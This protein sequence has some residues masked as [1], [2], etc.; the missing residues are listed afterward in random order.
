MIY[1]EWSFDFILVL[2]CIKDINI[3]L[4][5]ENDGVLKLK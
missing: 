4:L 2:N 1:M 5:I 3:I